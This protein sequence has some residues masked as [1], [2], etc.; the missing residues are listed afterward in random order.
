VS[1]HIAPGAVFKI[2][3][4]NKATALDGSDDAKQFN[5]GL[6]FWF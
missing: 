2:D 6:G 4:Q 3:Y 5:V 1:Y